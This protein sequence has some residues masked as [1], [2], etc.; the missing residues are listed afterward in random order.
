MI[1]IELITVEATVNEEFRVS[2]KIT[3]RNFTLAV[4]NPISSFHILT[5]QLFSY[6]H[7]S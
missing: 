6:F 5:L 4:S 2:A 3:V 7:L 1:E